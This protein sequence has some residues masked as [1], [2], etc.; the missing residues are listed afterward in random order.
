V[1]TQAEVAQRD[2]R[3]AVRF[4]WYLL[5]GATTV[6][7][8]GNIAH[9]ACPTYRASSSRLAV[10]QCLPSLCSQRCTASPSLSAQEHLAPSTAGPLVLW[11]PS[12][13]VPLRSASWH[14]EI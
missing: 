11:P 14:C 13:S 7:L 5:V 2:H 6:S 3:R 8:I 10:L 4:F 12:A 1:T 9:S